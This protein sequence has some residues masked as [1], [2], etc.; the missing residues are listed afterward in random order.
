MQENNSRGFGKIVP[1]KEAGE[2]EPPS[3]KASLFILFLCRCSGAYNAAGSLWANTNTCVKFHCHQSRD[4]WME[5]IFFTHL[6]FRLLL[7]PFFPPLFM[8]CQQL[9]ELLPAALG[10]H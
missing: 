6:T 4:V 7:F 10:V 1:V 5:N 9:G 3:V 2:K 8:R